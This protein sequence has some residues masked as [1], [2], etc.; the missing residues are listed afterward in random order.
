M[1]KF[2][3]KI[4]STN[5]LLRDIQKK[6][7]LKRFTK[8]AINTTNKFDDQNELDFLDIDGEFFNSEPINMLGIA[9]DKFIYITFNEYLKI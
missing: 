3:P 6:S 4:R 7:Q 5:E 8:K 1:G 9:E 2:I